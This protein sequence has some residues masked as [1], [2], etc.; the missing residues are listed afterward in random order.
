MKKQRNYKV[1]H[2]TRAHDSVFE[3]KTN[4]NPH[5]H[6]NIARNGNNKQSKNNDSTN[7]IAN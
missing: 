5:C 6:S 3:N 2:V 4:T 1:R 7:T